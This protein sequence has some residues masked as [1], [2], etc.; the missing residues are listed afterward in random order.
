MEKYFRKGKKKK[1]E[2]KEQNLRN[3]NAGRPRVSSRALES[4]TSVLTADEL[5]VANVQ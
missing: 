4:L 5:N 3:A 2:K 1:K